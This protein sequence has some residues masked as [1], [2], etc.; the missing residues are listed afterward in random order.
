MLY[1]IIFLV[2]NIKTNGISHKISRFYL[3][4]VIDVLE[5]LYAEIFLAVRKS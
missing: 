1:K 3:K 2:Y 5:I 4:N